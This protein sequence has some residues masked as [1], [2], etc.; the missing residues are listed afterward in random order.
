MDNLQ[1]RRVDAHNAQNDAEFKGWDIH[2]LGAV[3]EF[4][5]AKRFRL[6]WSGNM[7]FL[8]APDVAD[9]EVRSTTGGG[10]LILHP[11]SPDDHI[12]VHLA[13]G[14]GLTEAVVRGWMFGREGKRPE[15]WKD[16]SQKNRPAFFVPNEWPP[17][18]EPEELEAMLAGSPALAQPKPAQRGTVDPPSVQ[19]FRW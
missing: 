7:G 15:W 14:N 10:R 4:A 19:S 8:K 9:L 1:R 5:V 11:T 16:P 17:L 6:F 12:F 13:F 3:G 18:R 2:I